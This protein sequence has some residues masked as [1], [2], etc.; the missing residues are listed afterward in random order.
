MTEWIDGTPLSKVAG[1][2][3]EFACREGY[4]KGWHIMVEC[5]TDKDIEK[6]IVGCKDLA[7]AKRAVWAEIGDSADHYEEQTKPMRNGQAVTT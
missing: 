6:A 3:Y 1:E 5:W 2:L 4:E 7:S